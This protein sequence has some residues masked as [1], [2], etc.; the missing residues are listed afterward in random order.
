MT[1]WGLGSYERTAAQLASAAGRAVDAAEIGPGE[2]VLDVACG[3]G[4]AALLAAMRGA[5]VTGV[6]RSERLLGVAAGRAATAGIEAT[7]TTGEATALPVAAD[8]FDATLSVFGVIFATPADEAVAELVRV[9][10][11]DGRIVLTTWTTDGAVAAGSAVLR[12]AL[13]AA[14]G[15]AGP[16]GADVTAGPRAGGATPPG[17]PNPRDW[18]DPEHLRALF[19]P[20]GI[21]PEVDP[22][23]HVFTADSAA[24]FADEWLDLHPL[25]LAARPVLGDEAYAALRGPLIAALEGG[26]EDPGA[27]RATSTAMLVRADL[28]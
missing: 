3:T 28:G 2:R 9:T 6:D 24:A 7:W 5:V 8:A 12:S 21:V 20:H 1:D 11:P 22:F 14:S 13:A 26:N 19:A 17:G 25:W 16:V 18:G 4:N 27:F 15:P 10:A 23:P